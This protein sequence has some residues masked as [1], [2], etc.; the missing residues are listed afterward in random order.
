MAESILKKF[1]GAPGLGVGPAQIATAAEIYDACRPLPR[2][3]AAAGLP[4][5]DE[6]SD[7]PALVQAFPEQLGL[8]AAWGRFFQRRPDVAARLGLG[9]DDS[10]GLIALDSSLSSAEE[11]AGLLH[12]G[13]ATGIIIV[14]SALTRNNLAIGAWI[15]RKSAAIAELRV[16]QAA[17]RRLREL[18]K[19]ALARSKDTGR[20]RAGKLQ[21][22]I[23]QHNRRSEDL[24]RLKRLT[25]AARQGG[26]PVLGGNPDGSVKP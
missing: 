10:S 5:A 24:R 6:G 15:D 22:Q 20:R 3:A 26:L 19:N 2:L 13:A 21:Q 11:A 7:N 17:E 25:E 16:T 9:A 18:F 1:C 23:D 4:G 12:T 14:D 8:T